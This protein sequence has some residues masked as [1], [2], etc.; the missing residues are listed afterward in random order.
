MNKS[1]YTLIELLIVIG[2]LSILISVLSQVFGS[3]M[4]MKLSASS[5]TTLSQDTRYLLARLTYDLSQADT[6]N[7]PTIGSSGTT[8]VLTKN[9]ETITYSLSG[10]TLSR[11][12]NLVS[13]DHLTSNNT[14]ISALNFVRGASIGTSQS[15]TITATL[16]SNIKVPGK[17][18]D[19][20]SINTTILTR[21]GL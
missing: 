16:S 2:I 13:T 1:G 4:T 11:G 7:S 5:H 10:T 20:Q 18:F 6:I 21:S 9:S 15:L 17:P 14:N 3:I 12:S 19:T 8:L